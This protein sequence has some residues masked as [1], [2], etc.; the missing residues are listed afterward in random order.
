MKSVHLYAWIMTESPYSREV[1]K[2]KTSR[3]FIMSFRNFAVVQG[4][5]TGYNESIHIKN[6]TDMV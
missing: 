1:L 6:H 4:R 3:D 2:I 5:K